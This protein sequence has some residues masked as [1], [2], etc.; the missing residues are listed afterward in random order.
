[1]SRAYAAAHCA[2]DSACCR[3]QQ[4][5]SVHGTPARSDLR[6]RPLLT[7]GHI[8]LTEGDLDY[9]HH[10]ER[11]WQEGA[12]GQLADL[13]WRARARSRVL[14]PAYAAV[15]QVKR[16][17]LDVIP[18][19]QLKP[20]CDRHCAKHNHFNTLSGSIMTRSPSGCAA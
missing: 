4:V 3:V 6:T 13:L 9:S 16:S 15:A 8:V 19:T 10:A 5:C 7:N 2:A 18:N 20:C 17:M 11:A 12:L 14:A 1:M